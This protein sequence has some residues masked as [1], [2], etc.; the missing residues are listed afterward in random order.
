[1]RNHNYHFIIV[2]GIKAVTPSCVSTPSG[3]NSFTPT[4]TPHNSPDG[5]PTS[6]RSGSPVPYEELS[7]PQRILSSM[8]QLFGVGGGAKKKV[9]ATNRRDK[10]K[11][12]QQE[13]IDESLDDDLS[14]LRLVIFET[15]YRVHS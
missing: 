9:L 6:S 1:M 12:Q 11:K 13:V 4:A 7:I 14:L 15:F 3:A 10:S 2:L 8:P 5:S